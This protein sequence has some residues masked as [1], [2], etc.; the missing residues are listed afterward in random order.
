MVVES[1][2]PDSEL[3]TRPWQQE[4][5]DAIKA[6]KAAC[7]E[8][9]VD[10]SKVE[11]QVVVACTMI[12]KL[13]VEKAVESIEKWLGIKK[14]YSVPMLFEGD[15]EAKINTLKYYMDHYAVCGRDEGGRN[16]MWINPSGGIE[17]DQEDECL[18]SACFFMI[19]M[20][21]DMHTMRHGSSMVMDA[22]VADR[23]IGNEKKLQRTWQ[24]FPNRPQHIIIINASTIKRLAVNFL[25]KFASVFSS[26][27]IFQRLRF[28]NIDDV[29][30]RCMPK[31]SLPVTHGGPSRG[32]TTDWV[33]KRLKAFPMP[34]KDSVDALADGVAKV[35]VAPK[36]VAL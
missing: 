7:I 6:V 5:L 26:N 33:I 16:V 8:K 27:K 4:E 23:K 29:T 11:D 21:A 9:G 25:V 15:W 30:D 32:S 2:I 13:R 18:N 12:G 24:E 34:P 28:G 20:N 36:V 22:K 1:T 10:M 14:L 31:D 35:K 19:A 17:I 3:D